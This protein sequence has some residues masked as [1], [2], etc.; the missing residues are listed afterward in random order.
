MLSESNGAAITGLTAGDNGTAII[1]APAGG[2][3]WVD[4][5]GGITLYTASSA[6][7]TT[8]VTLVA[9]VKVEAE[10]GAT[11]TYVH[12]VTGTP[13]VIADG[14]PKTA[15]VLPGT[16]LK[17]DGAMD[18]TGVDVELTAGGAIFEAGS[19]DIKAEA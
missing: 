19:K 15:Y 16:E 1:A 18:I 2:A 4:A 6:S 14:T 5:T 11:V 17:V 12:P 10:S 8:A 3:E 9:A 7:W 13:T